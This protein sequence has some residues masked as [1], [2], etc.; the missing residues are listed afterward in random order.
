MTA[1]EAKAEILRR[2]VVTRQD[3]TLAKSFL[4]R[5]QDIGPHDPFILV[6]QF[7][8]QQ[9]YQRPDKIVLHPSVDPERAP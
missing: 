3:V 4:Q 7:S 8:E 2:V 9:G 6:N 1:D 5:L